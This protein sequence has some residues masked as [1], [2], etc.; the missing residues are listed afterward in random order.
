MAGR[1]KRDRFGSVFVLQDCISSSPPVLRCDFPS[2]WDGR[3]YFAFSLSVF[4]FCLFPCSRIDCTCRVWHSLSSRRLAESTMQMHVA[5][6]MHTP[7]RSEPW[8]GSLFAAG[9]VFLRVSVIA[10]LWTCASGDKWP[11]GDVSSSSKGGGCGGL[12]SLTSCLAP[13]S[14]RSASILFSS[15]QN[16]RLRID[17]SLLHLIFT[18]SNNKARAKRSCW[19]VESARM[20]LKQAFSLGARQRSPGNADE[21]SSRVAVSSQAGNRTPLGGKNT[22]SVILAKAAGAS[23][24]GTKTLKTRFKQYASLESFIILNTRFHH[25]ALRDL[26]NSNTSICRNFWGD[27]KV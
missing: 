9:C 2:V 17:W 21:P 7:W 25:V 13:S 10:P 3:L 16:S 26:W 18:R 24:Y 8:M 12:S 4:F 5:A 27:W 6:C 19:Q 22:Q 1:R 14:Y 23:C 20:P 11:T 15:C